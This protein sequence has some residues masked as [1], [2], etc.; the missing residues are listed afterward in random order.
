MLK[1]LFGWENFIALPR[2]RVEADESLNEGSEQRVS[3]QMSI[4]NKL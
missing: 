1:E 3:W 2:N 4:V